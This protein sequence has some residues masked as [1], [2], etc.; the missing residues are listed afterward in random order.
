MMLREAWTC[1]GSSSWQH[2]TETHTILRVLAWKPHVSVPE[3]IDRQRRLESAGAQPGSRSSR[4]SSIRPKLPSCPPSEL[5]AFRSSARLKKLAWCRSAAT[6]S[7]P[8]HAT[9]VGSKLAHGPTVALEAVVASKRASHH[10][11]G[12]RIVIEDRPKAKARRPLRHGG[13]RRRRQQ[14][15]AGPLP[16]PPKATGAPPR[17]RR[18]RRGRGR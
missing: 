3:Q 8:S 2:S 1:R 18:A 17:R 16:K 15:T 10:R 11:V 4:T 12:A 14:P 6:S 5:S 7:R 9:S 13:R